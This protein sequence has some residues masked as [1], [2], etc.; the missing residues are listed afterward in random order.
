[1]LPTSLHLEVV[2]PE[3]RLLDET[4]DEVVLPG[5]QGYLG[6]LP[7]HAPLL[8][9]LAIG[10]LEY[11]KGNQKHYLAIAWG[12]AEVLPERVI[13]LANIAERPEDIDLPRAEAKKTEIEEKIRRAQAE[14]DLDMLTAS[15]HKSVTRIQVA[16]RAQGGGVDVTH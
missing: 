5:S 4:V 8:T 11:R 1:M 15:L 16:R 9:S 6:V 2:T 3:R 13:V 12:F 10:V 14:I 7:G